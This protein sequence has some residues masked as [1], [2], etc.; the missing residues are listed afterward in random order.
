MALINRKHCLLREIAAAHLVH[1]HELLE[2]LVAEFRFT[3][4]FYP[5]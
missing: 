4:G 5:E 2:D 1:D 3:F